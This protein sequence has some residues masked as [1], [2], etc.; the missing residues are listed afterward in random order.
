LTEL[1]L[2]S[3]LQRGLVPAG[4]SAALTA[5]RTSD[6]SVVLE[7]KPLEVDA[8]A[9]V[10]RGNFA[11]EPGTYDVVVRFALTKPFAELTAPG[12]QVIAGID[13]T[14]DWSG[15]TVKDLGVDSDS[16]G[17]TDLQEVSVG[18]DPSKALCPTGCT[19]VTVGMGGAGGNIDAYE[20]SVWANADCSGKQYGA[21]DDDYPAGFADDVESPGITGSAQTTALYA[22][23]LKSAV[24]ARFLTW[25]QA[26]AACT[27]AGKRLCNSSEWASACAG[28]SGCAYPYDTVQC[29]CSCSYIAT[30]NT[31]NYGGTV[32]AVMA[33][34]S[35]PV[36]K[37][38]YGAYDMSGN[39]AELSGNQIGAN[40]SVEL[41]GGSFALPATEHALWACNNPGTTTASVIS[42]AVGF[43][44]CSP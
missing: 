30:D 11:L 6:G 18:T 21:F 37:S 42:A 31:C 13:T 19:S 17:A 23:S 24:P 1:G 22:C 3:W 20:A 44:C 39:L 16:D 43:R 25:R 15:K 26:R 4:L 14:V 2:P 36:C 5:T 33:T 7:A 12:V 28:P 9:G 32:A 34:G 38:G 40:D 10:A 8:T 29:G 35:A 27:N 41:R